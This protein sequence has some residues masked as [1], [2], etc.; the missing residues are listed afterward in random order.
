MSLLPHNIV[1]TCTEHVRR[2]TVTANCYFIRR[3]T[4]PIWTQ[5]IIRASKMWWGTYRTHSHVI[6]TRKLRTD[7][8]RKHTEY[9]GHR[10]RLN[11][12][13][14][15]F[16]CAW[17]DSHFRAIDWT[18]LASGWSLFGIST[19]KIWQRTVHNLIECCFER[20]AHARCVNIIRSHKWMNEN[21]HWMAKA[22]TNET[23]TQ[24]KMLNGFYS[25]FHAMHP[26]IFNALIHESKAN[27]ISQLL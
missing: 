20:M 25:P 23:F 6:Y 26:F 4:Q 24:L 10:F 1:A 17:H 18:W 27:V 22:Y 14:A 9:T 13:I 16:M 21:E 8:S 11:S 19:Y 3:H 7:K 12:S 15:F 2:R 5:C